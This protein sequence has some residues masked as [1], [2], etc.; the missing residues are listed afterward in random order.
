VQSSN[1]R[2]FI[3]LAFASRREAEAAE[4]S[5]RRKFEAIVST[6]TV[7]QGWAT[8]RLR[9]TRGPS[10]CCQWPAEIFR[11]ILQIWKFLKLA[12]PEQR[13]ASIPSTYF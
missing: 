12:V 9:A 10:Q 2:R 3:L 6:K 11:K 8:S 5:R 1:K 7:E 13:L 4:K